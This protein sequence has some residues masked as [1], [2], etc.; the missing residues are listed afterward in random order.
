MLL[1]III[2]AYNAD[3]Y[4]KRCVESCENQNI[5]GNQY[6]LVIVDDGSLDN[7]LMIAKKLAKRYENIKVFT[8]KNQGTASARNY[9]MTKAIGQY[10]W[11][12][13]ADDYLEKDTFPEI[14]KGIDNNRFHDI[15]VVKMDVIFK[16]NHNIKS[17]FDEDNIEMTG[18]D[19]VISKFTPSSVCT[20]IC[21]SSFIKDNDLF[22]KKEMYYEDV[23]FNLR[24]MSLAK[25]VFFSDI[26]AY[27]YDMHDGSKT[28]SDEFDVVYKKIWGN[29][30][31]VLS[32]RNFIIKIDDER[33]NRKILSHCN[34]T[35]A[36][37][38]VELKR[39]KS[40][41]FTKQVKNEILDNM[42]KCNCYPVH[43]PFLSWKMSIYCRLLNIRKFL[44]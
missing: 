27:D 2:P 31:L 28:V 25:R 23:D 6:E 26:V 16:G 39:E 10:F 17:Y 15:F 43:G 40:P 37:M 32:W 38:L 4:I 14:Y 33:L 30:P 1:S 9:G 20:M 7:T 13:D 18:R 5:S 29:V 35:L 11:F 3:Q 34:S 24:C 41:L 19:V 42:I 8:Q 12:I 21:K 36:G 44:I 22:F